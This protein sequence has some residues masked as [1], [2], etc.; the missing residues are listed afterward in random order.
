MRN[1]ADWL[2]LLKLKGSIGKVGNDDIGGRRF[3]YI[4]TINTGASG[5]HL[6]MLVIIGV[7]DILR[8]R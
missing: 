6:V 1:S 7:K 4:T 5:Y 2:T 8:V 3:A